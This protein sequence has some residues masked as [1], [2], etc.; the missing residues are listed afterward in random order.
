MDGIDRVRETGSIDLQTRRLEPLDPVDGGGD[1][2]EAGLG[3]RNHLTVL[4][5]RI[6]GDDEKDT[7][8][9]EMMAGGSRSRE[10]ADVHRIE[11]APQ[12]AQPLHRQ[13]SSLATSFPAQAGVYEKNYA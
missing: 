13:P 7:R 9:V 1:H 10:M 5:P 2:L 6:S 12:D 4:L 3:R 11:R 8:Q